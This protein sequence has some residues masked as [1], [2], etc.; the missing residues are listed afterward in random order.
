[1]CERIP[2]LPGE[3]YLSVS[4]TA[5]A[6]LPTPPEQLLVNAR[7]ALVD[8]SEAVRHLEAEDLRDLIADLEEL[9]RLVSGL[10]Q[11]AKG[12]SN[13]YD[14][15]GHIHSGTLISK[16][17]NDC[18]PYSYLVTSTGGGRR[19]WKYLGRSDGLVRSRPRKLEDETH[20]EPE[21]EKV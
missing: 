6:D 7:C 16:K 18:G 2:V 21:Q 15:H 5:P 20:T 9:E 11:Q 12:L 13:V 17:I 14:S 3:E 19:Q 8:F 10:L 1:V 4:T